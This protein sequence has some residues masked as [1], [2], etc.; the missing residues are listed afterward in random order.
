ME[1]FKSFSI[2]EKE[3]KH[4]KKIFAS[5]PHLYKLTREGKFLKFVA[6]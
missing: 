2:V 5:K 6:V 3:A 4:G 1:H